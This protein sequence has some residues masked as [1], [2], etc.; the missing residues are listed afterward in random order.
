MMFHQYPMLSH[1]Y[2]NHLYDA[3]AES[4]DLKFTIAF[5]IHHDSL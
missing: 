2:T 3:A 1:E 5:T 4:R